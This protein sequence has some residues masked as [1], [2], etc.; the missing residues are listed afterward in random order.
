MFR[1]NVWFRIT[2]WA[3]TTK[4]K[5]LFIGPFAY[6]ILRHYEFKYGIHANPNIYIGRGLKIIHG[7]G[8]YLNASYIGENFTCFQGVT[9]GIKDGGIPVVM[10]NVKIYPNSVICGE[11]T[12]KN[13]CVV[14]ALSYV[15]K[16]VEENAV[17]AGAPA[18]TL[19][20]RT[21]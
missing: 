19:N 8:V 3:R 16:S 18:H 1:Y 17:V 9:L 20:V 13:A 7:D 12:L 2:Q 14:G 6:F 11:I 21:A 15:D 4:W 5:K 10:D